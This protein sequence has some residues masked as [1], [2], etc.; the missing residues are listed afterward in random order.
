VQPVI[1]GIL[2]VLVGTGVSSAAAIL[3][4]AGGTTTTDL[5]PW[6]SGGGA[7]TAVAGIVYIAKLMATGKLVARDPALE[8]AELKQLLDRVLTVATASGEREDAYRQLLLD[9][10]RNKEPRR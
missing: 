5:A 2:A 4:A 8:A 9:G 7:A 6:V 1:R 3:A 10:M